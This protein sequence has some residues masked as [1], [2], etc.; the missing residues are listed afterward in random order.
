MLNAT[1]TAASPSSLFAWSWSDGPQR[2]KAGHFAEL[3]GSCT[4]A[5]CGVKL[6]PFCAQLEQTFV[7]SYVCVLKF[8]AALVNPEPQLR[9]TGR[10]GLLLLLFI[11]CSVRLVV[12]ADC[13]V[14]AWQPHVRQQSFGTGLHTLP[15]VGQLHSSSPNFV[16]W[17]FPL[18][19]ACCIS[20]HKHL[21]C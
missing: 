18:H 6:R 13:C 19:V 17:H 16:S 1:G 15:A 4:V 21:S 8:A 20:A 12:H 10:A 9:P 2:A 7:C 14:T 3:L 5:V 11:I